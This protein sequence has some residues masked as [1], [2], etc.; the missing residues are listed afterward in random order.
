MSAVV[1]RHERF[2]RVAVRQPRR[3]GRLPG[4]VA[5]LKGAARLRVGVFAEVVKASLTENNGARVLITDFDPKTS[6]CW[7]CKS[8]GRDI[9]WTEGGSGRTAL[10]KSRNLRRLW[11]GL[12]EREQIQL[13]MLRGAS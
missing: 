10:F 11:V 13:R 1:L 4:N 7:E 5:S 9:Q 3:R 12:G 6:H 2:E 8:L